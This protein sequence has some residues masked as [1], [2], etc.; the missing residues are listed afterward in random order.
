MGVVGFSI[1]V[2]ITTQS[3]NRSLLQAA[4]RKVPVKCKIFHGFTILFMDKILL[5]LI[6]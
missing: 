1:G 2:S 5:K 4:G 3:Q 6:W